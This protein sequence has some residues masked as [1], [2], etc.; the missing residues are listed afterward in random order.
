MQRTYEYY[1]V[2]PATWKD[3]KLINNVKS[4]TI[5]RD[6]E[7]ETLS[8]ATIDVVDSVGECYIR[9]Y[10]IVIQNGIREK[11]PLGTFIVQTPSS[12]FNGKIR[13]VSMDAYSPLLELKE[14]QPPLGYSLLK[15]ENI[16]DAVY[17]IVRENCRAPVSS[18]TCDEKL[19]NDFVSNADDTWLTFTRDLMSNAKYIYDLDEMGRVLFSPKQN[20]DALQPIWTFDDGN[21]S[22][23]NADIDM[24]HDL[25]G[26][27]N[28]V[29]VIYSNGK[30]YYHVKIVNDD[31]NSPISTINRGREI[32]KRVTDISIPGIPSEYAVRQYANQLLRELSS[33]EYTVTYS[34]GYCPVRLGDCVR[35]NYARAG[36]TDVKAKVISQSIECDS[37]CQVNET[38]IF[39]TKLWG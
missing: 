35:L 13:S 7:A 26:V 9:I 12:S 17:K 20:L 38:A 22:I 23:L 37:K 36:I 18:A 25:Y 4:C 28:A 39:T 2:D 16:M 32:C 6:L 33:I 3:S 31:P 30:D 1:V 14:N 19:Y 10:M 11:Y 5:T 29:E 24:Q 21:S 15:E 27:P 8:S 34:H